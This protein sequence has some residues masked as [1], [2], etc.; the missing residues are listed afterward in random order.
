M[1]ESTSNRAELRKH[2]IEAATKAF[3]NNG[4]K[5]VTMDDIAHLLKMS[6]RTLYQLFHDK[7][8]LVL[9][10]FLNR[11]NEDRKF[12]EALGQTSE[13]VLEV[14]LQIYAYKVEEMSAINPAFFADML[15]FPR[16]LDYQYR[17]KLG[18]IKQGVEFMN[19]GIEQG[20]FRSDVDF[21]IVIPYMQP[22][23]GVALNR[24]L[25]P[26]CPISHYIQNT[27]LIVLRGCCT[28]KGAAI[29]DEFLEKYQRQ[30]GA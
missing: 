16:V 19:R 22:K 18:D 20:L 17:R 13:N 28:P 12:I 14:V 21:N 26:E 23:Q 24:E 6:K 5:S 27:L 25:F 9:A 30:A 15:K 10:C 29:I 7:E 3:H 1:E 2:I 11:A 4:I 8:E